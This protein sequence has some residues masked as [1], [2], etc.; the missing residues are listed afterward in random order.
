MSHRIAIISDVHYA[1]PSEQQRRGHE[2]AAIS[3]PLQ[4]F[5]VAAFRYFIWMRDPFAHNHLLDRILSALGHVDLLVGL[6]DYSC[7]TGFIGVSDAAARE[8]ASQCL[9]KMFHADADSIHLVLGDHELGKMSLFGGRG[10][11]RIQSYRVAV[12]ELG[13]PDLWSRTI[14]RWTLVGVTSSLL[15]LP[16][17]RPET[18]HSEVSDWEQLRSVY[19]DRFRN[20]LKD[21]PAAQRLLLF[22]H[23]PT[24]IPFLAQI[25]EMRERLPYLDATFIG[26]LHSELFLWKSR[27]LAGMPPIRFLGNAVRRITEALHE[28]RWW[29]EFKVRL[30]PSLAGIQL[31]KDGGFLTFDL[32]ENGNDQLSVKRHWTREIAPWT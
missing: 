17:Y 3:N 23:D 1:G 10:G 28:A 7:D 6:G 27:I 15:A 2:L 4:R 20:V 21:L 24:A 22:C 11:L 19:I 9:K 14:G 32:E 18:L 26:H 30:C 8:S 12:N 5:G 16:V 13:I 29:K 31:R 25:P